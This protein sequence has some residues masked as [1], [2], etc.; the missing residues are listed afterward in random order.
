[1][2]AP[3]PTVTELLDL[4]RHAAEAGAHVIGRPLPRDS[5]V[6]KGAPGD[7]VTQL[8]VAAERRVRE[9]LLEA[10]PHDR[11]VGEELDDAGAPDA[12]LRWS[13][14]PLDGTTNKVKGLPFYATSVAVQST[15]T[16]EWLAGA[17]HAPE[18]SKEYFAARGQGAWVKFGGRVERLSGPAPD[19]GTRLLGTG[20]SY[21]SSVRTTQL[22]DLSHYM[23]HFDD[24][25]SLGSAALGLCAVA[26]GSV[27]AFLESDLYEFDWAAAA[28]IAEEAGASVE[29]PA[30]HRG[31]I[32]AYFGP[33]F[34]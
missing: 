19:A 11:V 29:R 6:T 24:M 1:M 34:R 9:F 13:I 21:D 17:V 15:A 20:L 16:G 10:R 25:R 5:V 33:D 8:D 26:D 30:Q 3:L 27:D 7:I 23:D 14:D 12:S 22:A 31:G 4:A 28:L 18:L 32:L 2:T